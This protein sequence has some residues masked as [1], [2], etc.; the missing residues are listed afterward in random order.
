[1]MDILKRLFCLIGLR[2]GV[3]VCTCVC[4]YLRHWQKKGRNEAWRWCW[5]SSSFFDAGGGG[6][7][8]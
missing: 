3:Y 2:R 4:M 6:E 8:S 5:P 1:M 7:K